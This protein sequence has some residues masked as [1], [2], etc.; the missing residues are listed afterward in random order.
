MIDIGGYKLSFRAFP[1]IILTR[2]KC[3]VAKSY[4]LFGELLSKVMLF[5]CYFN[6]FCNALGLIIMFIFMQRIM[7]PWVGCL[8]CML[9]WV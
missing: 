7:G 9:T 8:P 5:V 1:Y 2:T 4:T 3:V 6:W